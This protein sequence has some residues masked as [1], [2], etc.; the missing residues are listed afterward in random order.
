MQICMR[1]SSTIIA[2]SLFILFTV[3]A[4]ESFSKETR[5][6]TLQRKLEQLVKGFRGDVGIYVRNLK[7][8]K[9]AAINADSLFPA[10]SLVKIPILFSLFEKIENGE[11]QYGAT[12]VYRDSL[13]Y[14]GDDILGAFKDT[15]TITLSKVVMLTLTTS[16]NTAS[17]WLQQ[18]AGTGLAIN[19]WLE[20]NN[21]RQSRVNSR[22]P[23]REENRRQYGWGQTTPREMAEML[24]MI[25]QGRAISKAA[26]DEMYR[27]LSRTYWDQEACSEIPPY[28]HVTSK[29]GAVDQS[30]SEVL[31]VSAPSGDYVFSVI[32]KNQQHTSW[33]EDN[34]GFVLLRSVSKLLWKY[35]EPKSK[36]KPAEGKEKY[37][38]E[39]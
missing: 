8:G 37:G 20:K 6:R 38:K 14:P 34:E 4:T 9:S 22:T 17:L 36:W 24:V 12:L 16:D 30:R 26:S 32:T 23:G 5:D 19:A 31:L 39:Y 13:L 33:K 1:M 35:Y 18:L 25:R 21:F 29:Q 3:P 28:I 7:T 10:A 27:C 15:A 2:L 11:L